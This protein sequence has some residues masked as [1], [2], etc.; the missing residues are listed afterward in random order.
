MM[1][2]GLDARLPRCELYIGHI[3]VLSTYMGKKPQK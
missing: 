2:M 1:E 3:Q